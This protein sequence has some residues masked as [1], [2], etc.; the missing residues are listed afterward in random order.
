VSRRAYAPAS[1]SA[2]DI[3][4]NRA[5]I[6]QSLRRRGVPEAE[7]DD[8]LGRVFLG[9]VEAIAE[10]R[11]RPDPDDPE[12][13][14]RIWLLKIAK[15]QALSLFAS[16]RF[17]YEKLGDTTGTP[18]VKGP[19]ERAAVVARSSLAQL[20]QLPEEQRELLL[21]L[22]SGTSMRELSI[23]HRTPGR[24]M[25]TRV[26]EARAALRALIERERRRR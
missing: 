24:T 21:E 26:E 17:K 9:A 23:T 12:T 11:Y 5:V 4:K 1:P 14:M 18:D 20:E 13:S 15:Y 22:A 2:H 10:G 25:Y 8:I 6:C 7:I 3:L 19:D 16:G